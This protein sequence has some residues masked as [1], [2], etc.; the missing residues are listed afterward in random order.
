MDEQPVEFR[1]I[2]RSLHE[3]LIVDDDPASRYATA[4]L[5]RSAGFRTREAATGAE[6]LRAADASISAIVVD[7]HLPDING[8]ELCRMLRSRPATTR[9]PVLHLTAAYVT[10]EDKVRGLDSG[11]DAYLTRPV[12]PAV[13]V[14]TVQAL[15]RARVAEEAMRGSEAKFR[16]IYAQAPSGIALLDE[17]GRFVDA[18]PAMLTLFGRGLDAV[19]GHS[20]MEFVAPEGLERGERFVREM[21]SAPASVE[22]PVQDPQGRTI[23]L[24]WSAA[25]PVEPHVNMAMATDVSQ[26]VLLER[27]RADLL[28]RERAARGA[29]EQ[30]SRMKDDFIAVLSHELRTP[31]NVISS[32]T[33]VLQLRGGNDETRRGLEVIERNVRMQARLIAD[34]LDMSLLNHGKLPLSFDAV[35]PGE[36]VGAAVNALRPALD[37]R[38]IDLQTDLRP[39]YRPIRADNARLQQIIWNLLGN[40]IK[41]SKRGGK[42][43]VV[44]K[45]NGD[46]VQIR[47]ADEGDGIAPEFLPYVFDRFAQGDEVTKRRQGG[48]GLGLSI[49]KQLVDAHGGTIAVRSPGLGQGAVFDVWLPAEVLVEANPGAAADTID[50]TAGSIEGLDLLIVED[51]QEASAM[52]EVILVNRGARVTSA[53]DYDGA[54]AL[55]EIA[56]PDVLIS[57]IGMPG[58]DGYDLIREIRRREAGTGR[59]L[60]AIAL[61]SFTRSQD[62]AQSFEAG[63]DAHCPKPLRPLHLMH[64]IGKVLGRSGFGTLR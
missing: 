17:Q 33:H 58:R 61:T 15:V 23:H 30:V 27:Q 25:V 22:L 28:E 34:L 52:L 59:R 13:L 35:D 42:I 5:L 40:A 12:E 14:A 37:E 10:D 50:H 55:L 57:D 43:A 45:Q 38:A 8:F 64:Q 6:G 39:P 36:A 51:D 1:P 31:L 60:P 48:L 49:V 56:E 20:L 21:E 4:R 46:G 18:N 44:L 24:E 2:D 54:L 3:L 53:R 32:W 62:Q 63:F 47:V 26:R 7:V 16:A 29:A 41:F 19:V 11:A 9:L